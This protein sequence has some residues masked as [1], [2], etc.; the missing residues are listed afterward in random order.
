MNKLIRIWTVC[1]VLVSIASCDDAQEVSPADFQAM[2]TRNPET[3]RHTTFIGVKGGKACLKVS[4]MS[5][6]NSQKWTEEYFVTDADKLPN[7]WLAK[8]ISKLSKK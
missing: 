3:M 8:R 7:E 4:A 2:L 1:L 5:S 6:L